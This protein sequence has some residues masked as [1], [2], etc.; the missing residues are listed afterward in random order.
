MAYSIYSFWA[1][2]LSFPANHCLHWQ[3]Q[4]Y[5]SNVMTLTLTRSACANARPQSSPVTRVSKTQLESHMRGT[6][7]SELLQEFRESVIDLQNNIGS[8]WEDRNLT[9]AGRTFDSCPCIILG[10]ALGVEQARS[11]CTSRMKLAHAGRLKNS[12][13]ALQAEKTWSAKSEDQSCHRAVGKFPSRQCH[14]SRNTEWARPWP[15]LFQI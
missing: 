15:L 14:Q 6:R 10:L 9:Q 1:V 12:G 3:Q 5:L 8:S 11:C 4:M 7:S 13:A 2:S